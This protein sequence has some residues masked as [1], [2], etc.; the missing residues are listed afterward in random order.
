MINHFFWFWEGMKFLDHKIKNMG[1]LEIIFRARYYKMESFGNL[2]SEELMI[3]AK[4]RNVDA[5][6]NMSRQFKQQKV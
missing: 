5:C 2:T 6:K 4:L 1:L 3:L